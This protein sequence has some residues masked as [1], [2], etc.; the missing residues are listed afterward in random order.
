[1]QKIIITLLILIISACSS[2]EIKHDYP[3]NP[4]NI[5]K[6]RAGKFFDEITVF[7]ANKSDKKEIV[8]NKIS[9]NKLWQS[10]IEVIGEILPIAV[11][12]ESSGLIITEWYRDG[13]DDK[14][15][16]I[17]LLVKGKELK[18]ENLQL[19]IFKQIKDKN[20]K[21]IDQNPEQ[22]SITGNLI[23]TKIIKKAQ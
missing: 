6:Q 17:N 15:I 21:W 23:K 12:D 1:M 5:R 16:K 10:A 4:E 22:K 14:K 7:D 20:G 13:D 11:A 18:K 2:G 19:T 9:K 8:E 3:E